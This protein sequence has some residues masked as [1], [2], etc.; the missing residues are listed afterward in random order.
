MLYKH[1]LIHV[2]STHEVGGISFPC[3]ECAIKKLCVDFISVA[4]F[5][6]NIS[7]WLGQMLSV[8]MLN[9][10]TRSQLIGNHGEISV[11]SM[12][13]K[14]KQGS[15][16][17]FNLFPNCP[18]AWRISQKKTHSSVSHTYFSLMGEPLARPVFYGLDF[19]K[20]GFIYLLKA[21]Y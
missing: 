12:W 10:Q 15:S 7:P 2:F 17:F 19:V 21:Q 18:R 9:K 20:R 3:S 5:W 4:M 6:F 1:E 16:F 8:V 13:L 14:V 11:R